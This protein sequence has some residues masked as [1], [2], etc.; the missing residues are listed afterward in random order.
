MFSPIQKLLTE[1]ST[2]AQKLLPTSTYCNSLILRICDAA[3]TLQSSPPAESSA[4][5]A[6]IELVTEMLSDP[7]ALEGLTKEEKKAYETTIKGYCADRPTM[8][9]ILQRNG[10][11]LRNAT[12]EVKNN[13]ELVCIAVLQN[14]RALEHASHRIRDWDDMGRWAPP[15]AHQFLSDGVRALLSLE[16]FI[17]NNQDVISQEDEGLEPDDRGSESYLR[18]S[19]FTDPLFR[20][21]F[22]DED[23]SAISSYK[24][25]I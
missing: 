6:H 16:K 4:V 22:L 18:D 10:L 8:E 1:V 23:Q 11:A 17:K 12:Q 2:P 7:K 5:N 15:E 9:K 13:A 20:G 24:T 14:P 25:E 19:F 21:S 3:S